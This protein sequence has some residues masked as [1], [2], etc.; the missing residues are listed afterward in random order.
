MVSIRFGPPEYLSL[1]LFSLTALVSFSNRS[2]LKGLIAGI[3]GLFL[4]TVGLDPMSGNPR[5]T[6]G[7]FD[8]SGG[9]DIIPVVMG[10]FGIA[11]VFSGFEEE[12]KSLYKGSLGSWIPE[13]KEMIRGL[14]ASVRGYFIGGILGLLPAC[15]QQ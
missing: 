10:L 2:L 7:V 12:A 11:E 13:R 4:A 8:L 6:F 3:L 15:P 9:L 1:V 5:L 14:F